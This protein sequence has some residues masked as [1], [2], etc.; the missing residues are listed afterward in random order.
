MSA[1]A[2]PCRADGRCQYAIDHGA[3]GL[4]A[5]PVGECCQQR[6]VELKSCPFCGGQVKL[7]M[8][9]V[10]RHKMFGLREFWGVVCRNKINHGFSCS[11]EQ[12]PSASKESAVSRWNMRDGQP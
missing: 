12:R 8:V 3:E 7:E 1:V 10:E 5:C 2:V 4:G 9:C 6:E 11:I